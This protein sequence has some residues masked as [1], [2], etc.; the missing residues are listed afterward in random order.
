MANILYRK[1]KQQKSLDNGVTWIDTGEYRVGD[2]LENPSNC[3]SD[4]SK[5]CRWIELPETEGYYCDGYNKYTVQVEECSEN[6]IIW[7]RTG[8][9]KKGYSLISFYS[10]ECG[11]DGTDGFNCAL[12]FPYSNTLTTY[13][14]LLGLFAFS[15][16]NYYFGYKFI[17]TYN[18]KIQISNVRT[19]CYFNRNMGY[20][21]NNSD[22]PTTKGEEYNNIIHV[23]YDS[24]KLTFKAY[25]YNDINK[26]EILNISKYSLYS[27]IEKNNCLYFLFYNNTEKKG[28]KIDDNYNVSEVTLTLFDDYDYYGSY[29][30]SEAIYDVNG[31]YYYRTQ[32]DENFYDIINSVTAVSDLNVNGIIFNNTFYKDA[33]FCFTTEKYACFTDFNNKKWYLINNNGNLITTLDYQITSFFE[34]SNNDLILMG[35]GKYY[36]FNGNTVEVITSSTSNIMS[37]FYIEK[38]NSS[39]INITPA[40][41]YNPIDIESA[42]KYVEIFGYNATPERNYLGLI[43]YIIESGGDIEQK[44]NED[45]Y[46]RKYCYNSSKTNQLVFNYTTNAGS[47]KNYIVTVCY[48]DVKKWLKYAYKIKYD[49]DI[50]V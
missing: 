13:R 41:S 27:T 18:T 36:Y 21:Y 16:N 20:V 26:I 32:G 25:Y 14:D 34:L 45:K 28:Y 4:D 29:F 9:Q 24:E 8:E 2:I 10:Q 11:Y 48:D 6:G 12:S 5:Q 49:L 23:D 19:S 38:L 37:G 50:E 42:K 7:T 33:Y 44:L 39:I 30:P 22:H 43:D 31:K 1:Q 46:N 35:N 17:Y 3:T 15:N 40:I 47:Y